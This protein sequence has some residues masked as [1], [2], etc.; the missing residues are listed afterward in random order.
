MKKA[1]SF[2]GFESGVMCFFPNQ[3]GTLALDDKSDYCN[4]NQFYKDNYLDSE[5][6]DSKSAPTL[7]TQ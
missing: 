1:T 7:R 4:E 6:I 3:E 5:G 2:I